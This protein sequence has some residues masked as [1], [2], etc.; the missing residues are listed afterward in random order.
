MTWD[1]RNDP[2]T[3]RVNGRDYPIYSDE[4]EDDGVELP[5]GTTVTQ[6]CADHISWLQDHPL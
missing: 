3:A 6:A 2:Q 5:D 1:E 4:L